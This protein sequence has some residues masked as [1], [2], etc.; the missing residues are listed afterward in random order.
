MNEK[1]KSVAGTDWRFRL[2]EIIFEA[3][4]PAGKAFDI[5]LLVCILLS[6]MAVLLESV[7]EIRARYGTLFIEKLGK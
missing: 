3:D 7:A 5:G 6:V 1:R 4:T 2:H